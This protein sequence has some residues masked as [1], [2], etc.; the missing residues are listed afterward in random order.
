MSSKDEGSEQPIQNT[1]SGDTAEIGERE[2][3]FDEHFQEVYGQSTPNGDGDEGEEGDSSPAVETQGTPKDYAKAQQ[4]KTQGNEYF[5]KKDWDEA[6]KTYQKAIEYC[7]HSE[8]DFLSKLYSNIAIGFMKKSDYK[9]VINFC[10]LSLD[11]DSTFAKPLVNRADAYYQNK[12]WEKALED[13]KELA[14]L[15]PDYANAAREE[16]CQREFDKEMEVK[17]DQVLGQLK[18]LGN[19]LLGKFGLSLDNFKM[20]KGEGGGYSVQFKQ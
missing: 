7:P 10:N 13:Y 14:K 16:I 12:Q 2:K 1:Q 20:E 8:T 19:S 18:D 15:G 4:L 17:K 6:I 3:L 11:L 5:A 9:N